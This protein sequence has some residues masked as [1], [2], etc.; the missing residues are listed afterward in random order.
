MPLAGG[1]H[2]FQARAGDGMVGHGGQGPAPAH[3]RGGELLAGLLLAGQ[4]A[5]GVGGQGGEVVP[6]G[7]EHLQ[8]AHQR[9]GA[10]P[11]PAVQGAAD[12]AGQFPLAVLVA[13]GE[14]GLQALL[15][16]GRG[17]GAGGGAALGHGGPEPQAQA[18]AVHGLQGVVLVLVVGAQ[19]AP[20]QAGAGG[21]ALLGVPD[22]QGEHLE[23]A[24]LGAQVQAL[25]HGPGLLQV[26][27]QHQVQ[28]P[29]EGSVPGH[30]GPQAGGV[31]DGVL[32][33]LQLGLQRVAHGQA[34]GEP[35][36]GAAT[37]A[38][39]GQGTRPE[40][41]VQAH[42]GGAQ[43]GQGVVLELEQGADGRVAAGEPTSV[44]HAH[45]RLAVLQLGG[46]EESPRVP[47]LDALHGEAPPG[48]PGGAPAPARQ[49]EGGVLFL[50]AQAEERGLAGLQLLAG[51]QAEAGRVVERGAG[52]VGHGGEGAAH[53]QGAVAGARGEDRADAA[54]V[55]GADGNGGRQQGQ[56]QDRQRRS[57]GRDPGAWMA[58]PAAAR[59]HR[60]T[61]T[62]RS[63]RS[64]FPSPYRTVSSAR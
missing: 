15:Q 31:G 18:E 63:R 50:E 56:E 62:L 35:P 19:T 5:P 10:L 48:E 58:A 44:A 4:A 51:D 57:G 26:R 23:D 9:Q 8:G 52:V 43:T 47:R 49:D 41:E 11:S 6:L 21:Q 45:L 29:A 30:A 22:A 2:A 40:A 54:V 34:H 25:V 42:A 33:E 13:P 46:A 53:G 16:G 12:R 38:G 28:G 24:A 59:A 39:Q 32:V 7:G 64:R 17:G 37:G 20:G 1:L 27:G 14:G 60:T 36:G 55:A 3:G 61:A